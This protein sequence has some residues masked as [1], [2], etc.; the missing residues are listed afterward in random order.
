MHMP[1]KS[2]RAF[3]LIELVV[4]I[5]I[6]AILSGVLVPRVSSHMRSA[7]D[8]KRL[9]D[10]KI[11]RSAIEQFYLDRG[12][13]PVANTNSSYG[14]WDVSHDGNFI[15]A[16]VEGG[17]LEDI[18]RD[19]V[20]DATYHYRYYVYAQGSYNCAGE[21]DFYV[22]VRNF[23]STEFASKNKGF[24]RCSGRNW[25]NEFAYVTG[26]GASLE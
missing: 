18:P 16:L 22:G 15:D 21:T 5:S 26:G 19:P 7:R 4:V 25:N 12:F 9:A 1:N 2:R 23:E 17:Y 13:Y 20:N 10:V 14:G 3:T 24:F 11:M 8:A 6:M